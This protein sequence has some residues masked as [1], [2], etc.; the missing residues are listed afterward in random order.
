M[1]HLFSK[2]DTSR[3]EQLQQQAMDLQQKQQDRLDSQQRDTQ[4]A[5]LARQ[6]ASASG[7]M[8]ML[9]SPSSIGP[10]GGGQSTLGSN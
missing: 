4:A 2:P 7:G 10:Q 3:Q 1:S 5:L 9:M 8:R 6:R